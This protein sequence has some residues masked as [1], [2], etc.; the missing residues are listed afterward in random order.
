MF[1]FGVGNRLPLGFDRSQAWQLHSWFRGCGLGRYFAWASSY[2]D[3]DLDQASRYRDEGVLVC[4]TVKVQRVQGRSDTAD[5]VACRGSTKEQ[6]RC[7]TAGDG[8]VALIRH[9]SVLTSDHLRVKGR[10]KNCQIAVDPWSCGEA[11]HKVD[12]RV[13]GRR[14]KE[15]RMA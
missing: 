4:H 15:L 2:G 5:E 6:S 12:S 1:A 7:N 11:Y 14:G 3:R 9:S 8:L 10:V 13:V